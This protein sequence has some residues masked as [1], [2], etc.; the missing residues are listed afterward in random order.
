MKI[1]IS[2]PDPLAETI[3]ALARR[4]GLAR[5]RLIAAALMEYVARHAPSTV[6]DRLDAV[7][8]KER[9]ELD[10]ALAAASEDVLHRSA[11]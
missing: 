4:R 9:G 1:A 8:A 11:W 5:S 3:D 2:L 7:Y 10:P 6:T